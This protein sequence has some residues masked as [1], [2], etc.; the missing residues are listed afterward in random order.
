MKNTPV[1]SLP[2]AVMRGT[3]F[4][5]PCTK[6]IFFKT[7]FMSLRCRQGEIGISYSAG[8]KKI[9]EGVRRSLHPPP[10][11]LSPPPLVCYSVLTAIDMGPQQH[12][13]M[14]MINGDMWQYRLSALDLLGP[15]M[16]FF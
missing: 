13:I 7:R 8:S 1:S 10:P 15:F 4:K 9:V 16:A 6:C 14:F 11:P 12:D 2:T 5:Q 3:E